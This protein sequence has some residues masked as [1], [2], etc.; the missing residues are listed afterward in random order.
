M[1]T[2]NLTST[3]QQSYS[4]PV[5]TSSGTS[6]ASAVDPPDNITASTKAKLAESLDSFSTMPTPR[7]TFL[8]PPTGINLTDKGA[9]LT[10][11]T[12]ASAQPSPVWDSKQ[13][14][15]Q[16]QSLIEQKGILCDSSANTDSEKS[17][18]SHHSHQNQ[19]AS[20][21]DSYFLLNQPASADDGPQSREAAISMLQRLASTDTR[22]MHYPAI[23]NMPLPLAPP[24][25]AL[26]ELEDA[27]MSI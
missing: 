20:Y 25:E 2:L 10:S 18:D 13:H 14:Q 4:R 16:L 6:V 12:G 17:T 26:V 22:G 5:S 23:V 21:D 9:Y 19:G 8:T 1:A 27:L 24:V 3:K 15:E 7:N 11:A